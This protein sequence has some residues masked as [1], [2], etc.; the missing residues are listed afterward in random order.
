MTTGP[1]IETT[2]DDGAPSGKRFAFL[3][4]TVIKELDKENE[5]VDSSEALSE[6]SLRRLENVSLAVQNMVGL[7]S[8]CVYAESFS[9]LQGLESRSPKALDG[10]V[11]EEAY[12]LPDEQATALQ[13]ICFNHLPTLTLWTG[14]DVP[15]E[16][17]HDVLKEAYE[18][19]EQDFAEDDS[20]LLLK[21][22][23]D[24]EPNGYVWSRFYGWSLRRDKLISCLDSFPFFRDSAI[25]SQYFPDLM[26]TTDLNQFDQILED[27]AKVLLLVVLFRPRIRRTVG[28]KT[29]PT[30]SVVTAGA[31]NDVSEGD[32]SDSVTSSVHDSE[33]SDAHDD[34]TVAVML[35]SAPA[36]DSSVSGYHDLICADINVVE[37][38]L[39]SSASSTSI[40][41][42]VCCDSGS[43]LNLI[44][45]GFVEHHGLLTQSIRP[46]SF[47]G[48]GGEVLGWARAGITGKKVI[49]T[50]KVAIVPA[51]SH[52]VAA[53]KEGLESVTAKSALLQVSAMVARIALQAPRNSS[54]A[55]LCV[56][57]GIL[58]ADME[59]GRIAATRLAALGCATT[60]DR[61]LSVKGLTLH[62]GRD[63]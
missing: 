35:G 45:S 15:E 12:V 62:E 46:T 54:N 57:A 58:P 14:V 10:G 59:L 61:T 3:K 7:T 19:L 60:L 31:G 52:A 22:W 18:R 63:G 34:A 8:F 50:Y 2:D 26:E 29:S 6:R 43:Q 39:R 55:A 30:T 17:C 47:S 25:K 38:K 33:S 4:D 48:I 20:S 51:L 24:L 44:T 36:S 13:E 5:F 23:V 28:A 9:I 40:K 21:H 49:K 27:M 11:L 37:G 56:A 41:V 1:D 32:H 53:W 42:R 16:G